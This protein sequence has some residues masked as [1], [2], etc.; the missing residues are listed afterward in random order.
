MMGMYNL[1]VFKGR[2]LKMPDAGEGVSGDRFLVVL[3]APRGIWWDHCEI[4]EA[5]LGGPLA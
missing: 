2:Y 3:C 5:G 4:Q 1:Q